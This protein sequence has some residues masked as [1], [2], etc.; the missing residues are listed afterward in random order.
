MRRSFATSLILSV[1]SVVIA[2]EVARAAS[3]PVTRP[4]VKLTVKIYDYAGVSPRTLGG[5]RAEAARIYRKAGLET[6]WMECAVDDRP[7]PR[8]PICSQVPVFTSLVLRILP[9]ATAE[10]FPVPASCFGYAAL[11]S[12]KG[13]FGTHADVF[14]HRVREEQARIPGGIAISTGQLLGQLIFTR[15]QAGRIHAQ[16]K[17]RLVSASVAMAAATGRLIPAAAAARSVPPTFVTKLQVR[18]YDY[19]RLSPAMI[20]WATEDAKEVLSEAGIP[21]RWLDCSMSLSDEELD[22]ACRV[23]SGPT[24]VVLKILPREMAERFTVPEGSFGFAVLSDKANG[25]GSQAVVFYHRVNELAADMDS[26]RSVA[27]GH[28]LAHEIGHLLLGSGSHSNQGIM[29]ATWQNGDLEKAIRGKFRFTPKQ[30]KRMRARFQQR[31]RAGESDQ[32]AAE[33]LAVAARP[34]Q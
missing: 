23:P 34:V 19:A 31:V 15:K 2:A 10:K 4:D 26:Y 32:A 13:E 29:K 18:L 27:L 24:V 6:V 17:E 14:V 16:W 21:T 3:A 7:G 33:D 8:Q 12:R 28:I 1:F 9:K 11:P 5:A 22:P 20:E 30:A 25:F